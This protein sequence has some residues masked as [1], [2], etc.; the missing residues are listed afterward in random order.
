MVSRYRATWRLS[1]SGSFSTWAKRF[2][3]GSVRPGQPILIQSGNVDG[4]EGDARQALNCL[5]EM[6][7]R[8]EKKEEPLGEHPFFGKMTKKEWH[9]LLVLHTTH[10]L[11]YVRLESE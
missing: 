4:L 11:G 9:D 2:E 8:F 10:H 5:S 3:R 7:D 6:I 1:A